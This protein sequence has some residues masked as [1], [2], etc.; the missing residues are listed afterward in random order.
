MEDAPGATRAPGFERWL[1][2]MRSNGAICGPASEFPADEQGMLRDLEIRS[3][4][5]VP[6]PGDRGLHGFLGFDACRSER[7]WTEP[8][9]IA[10]SAVALVL[11]AAL[12]R[13]HAQHEALAARRDVEEEARVSSAIASFARETSCEL[14]HP[15]LADSV[16]RR[17]AELLKCDAAFAVIWC[18]DEQAVRLAGSHGLTPAA[19]EVLSVPLGLSETRA[20]I[21]AMFGSP[22]QRTTSPWPRPREG[23]RG[24]RAQCRRDLAP[25]SGAPPRER[26]GRRYRGLSPRAERR[27]PGPDLRLARGLAQIASSPSRASDCSQGRSREPLNPASSRR[28]RTSCTPSTW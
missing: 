17:V 20:Q 28:C 9:R 6:V 10:L 7:T 5:A 16:C 23:I 18:E 8:E 21:E 1:E 26:A 3:L 15:S 14:R 12:D 27:L 11:G 25:P 4:L 22:S 2:R 19:H 13:Q 24:S